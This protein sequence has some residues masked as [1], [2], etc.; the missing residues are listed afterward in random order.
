M[1]RESVDE[2]IRLGIEALQENNVDNLID[3]L[4]KR[5]VAFDSLVKDSRELSK[6][7]L[8]ECRD[9]ETELLARLQKERAKL[10]KEMDDLSRS[11]KAVRRYRPKFPL[12]PAPAFFD[13]TT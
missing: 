7:E 3:A 1:S 4:Q 8:L 11:R 5:K 10:L 9:R 2:F 6:A 12:P 13:I